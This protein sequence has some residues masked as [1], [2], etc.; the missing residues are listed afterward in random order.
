MMNPSLWE[1][2]FIEMTIRLLIAAGLGGLIGL[3]RELNNHSAGFRTHILV[4]I[5]SASIM[6]LSIYGFSEFMYELNVR[7]DPARLAAQVISGI[8]FLGAGTIIR[9]GSS[10]S[11]LTTAASLWVVAAIGLCAGAGFYETAIMATTIAI[12]SLYLLNKMEKHLKSKSKGRIVKFELI[13]NPGS[14]ETVVS[15][16]GDLNIKTSIMVIDS[17][18]RHD[19][20]EHK[21]GTYKIE[22]DLKRTKRESAV[23]LIDFLKRSTDVVSIDSK[24]LT[25]PHIK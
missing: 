14:M 13:D 25:I 5:G 9:N 10:I 11:G 24:L 15:K 7:S 23:V 2:S 16:L 20:S 17:F 22:L 8:G 1:I 3:E 21:P 19:Q 12:V 6:L 4:C 18:Q